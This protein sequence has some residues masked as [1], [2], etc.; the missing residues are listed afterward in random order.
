MHISHRVCPLVPCAFPL[1]VS[2]CPSRASE[3]MRHAASPAMECSLERDDLSVSLI[4]AS[5][6]VTRFHFGASQTRSDSLVVSG[7]CL[8]T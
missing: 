2:L 7:P 4:R 1:L 5:L 3:V 6:L 8:Q